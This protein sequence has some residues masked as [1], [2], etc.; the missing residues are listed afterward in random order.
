MPA[1]LFWFS[2]AESGDITEFAGGQGAGTPVVQ[3]TTK[4]S[5]AYALKCPSGSQATARVNFGA[6]AADVFCRFY[7][8]IASNPSVKTRVWQTGGA[9]SN[10]FDLNLKTDGVLE[11]AYNG[12]VES[13]GSTPVTLSAWNLIEIHFVRSA[14]VGGMECLLN[15]GLEFSRFNLD[16]GAGPGNNALFRFGPRDGG[17]QDVY[18][19]DMAVATGAYIGPGQCVAV[20]GK[21][22]TPTYDA[23]TKNGAADAFGCWSQTP[24]D[25]SKNCSDTLTNDKQTMLVDDAAL[26]A[27]IGAADAINGAMVVMVAKCASS[28][29]NVQIMRRIGGADTFSANK[30]LSTADRFHPGG[31]VLGNTSTMDIFTD[32]RANLAAAEIGVRDQNSSILATV[33]DVWLMV[34]FTPITGTVVSRISDAPLEFLGGLGRLVA[35]PY[36]NLSSSIKRLFVAPLAWSGIAAR[37]FPSPAEFGGS[38]E[39]TLL[40]EWRDIALLSQELPVFWD[41]VGPGVAG[42][43]LV[44]WSDVE[45]IVALG[46]TWRVVPN[47]QPLFS[48]DIQLP[49][50]LVVE[51]S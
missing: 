51:I 49:S 30:V 19:D 40:V 24:F 47:E 38:V 10:Q 1:T 7:L 29:I 46:V 17:G 45:S 20:Q 21:S 37:A 28:N 2:G 15:A 43:L 36:E 8:F 4:R 34:D 42:A 9:G 48:A 22:G 11:F 41:D 39:L 26:T 6:A 14:T 33:E 5:G 3:T 23:W 13:T 50:T 31:V 44:R 35:V 32:T 18:Y 12:T 16:T 27:A 25:A